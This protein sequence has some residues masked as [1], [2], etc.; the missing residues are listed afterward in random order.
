MSAPDDIVGHKTLRDAKGRLYHEP[1]TRAE[2]DEIM[3]RIDAAKAK[4]AADMPTSEDAVRVLW[5]AW[6]RLKELGWQDPR[7]API[8]GRTKKVIELGSTGMHN[9]TCE[10]K[11]GREG[12]KWWW[13]HDEHDT[14]PCTPIFYLP[15]EQEATER[16]ARFA[17]AREKFRADRESLFASE[18]AVGEGERPA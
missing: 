6:Y 8:D 1:L 16:E 18:P 13:V 7:Y 14:Y 11:E 5:D 2:S 3:S 4:R 9:G 10:P 17:K 15:D 12:G